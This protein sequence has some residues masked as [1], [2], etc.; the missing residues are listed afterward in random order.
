MNTSMSLALDANVCNSIGQSAC[1]SSKDNV[2][3]LLQTWSALSTTLASGDVT[4]ISIAVD[5]CNNLSKRNSFDALEVFLDRLPKI[6]E[7]TNNQQILRSKIALALKRQQT[8]VV[9]DI[10]KV[11]S[12][13]STLI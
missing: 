3:E 12:F 2:G 4:L 9:Q 1:Q 8:K 6:S 13:I 5:I 11:G 7:Y 10:I